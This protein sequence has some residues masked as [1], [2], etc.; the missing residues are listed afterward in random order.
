MMSLGGEECGNAHLVKLQVHLW[1]LHDNHAGRRSWT[2]SRAHPLPYVANQMWV[3][4]EVV[5]DS[6]TF[7]Y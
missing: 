5:G 3:H 1:V 6:L 2:P 7:R 4:R